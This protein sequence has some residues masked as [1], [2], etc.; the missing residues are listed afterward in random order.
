MT[1]HDCQPGSAGFDRSLANL[2]AAETVGFCFDHSHDV[3]AGD[4]F[5]DARVVLNGIQINFN[6]GEMRRTFH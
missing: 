1:A 4:A 2:Y 5:N 3:H 6:P